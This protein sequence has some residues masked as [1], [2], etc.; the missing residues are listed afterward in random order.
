MED[1]EVSVFDPN[2]VEVGRGKCSSV[3]GSRIFVAPFAL[4]PYKVSIFPNAPVRDV[5]GRLRLPFLIEE[6]DGV[7]VGLSSI[8]P[9]PSLTR[10][11]WVLEITSEGGSKT[12]RFRRGGRPSD[13]GVVLSETDGFV[14]VDTVFTHIGVDEVDDTRNKEEMLYRFKI[15]VRGFEGFVIKSIVA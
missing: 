10:V 6:N 7:E 13:G 3:K 11:F 5:S 2:A 8:V 15:T 12:D 14:G 4:Y 9:H 1:V